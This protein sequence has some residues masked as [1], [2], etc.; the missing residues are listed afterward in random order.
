MD[1]NYILILKSENFHS[2]G[3]YVEFIKYVDKV[4]DEKQY[5]D[6]VG[7]KMIGMVCMY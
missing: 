7:K 1:K 4:I 6:R 2:K 3:S 5:Q